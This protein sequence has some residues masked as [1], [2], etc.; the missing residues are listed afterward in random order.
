M[1]VAEFAKE[2]GRRWRQ[3]ADGVGVVKQSCLINAFPR[4]EVL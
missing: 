4:V 2:I 3:L 1:M